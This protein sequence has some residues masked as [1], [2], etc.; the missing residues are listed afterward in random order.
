MTALSTLV[1]SLKREVAVP[2]TFDETFPS[3]MDSD[4]VATL[5]D[6]FGEAQLW[7]FF[8]TLSLDPVLTVDEQDWETS[9]PLSPGGATLVVL[10]AAARILRAQI[11][12]L[13]T[14]ERYKAGPVEVETQRAAGVLKDELDYVTTRISDLIKDAKTRGGVMV[15]VHDNYLNRGGGITNGRFHR[16][17]DHEYKG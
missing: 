12:S 16:F 11:R 5:A 15:T 17:Y 7:G 1:E 2:G 3:T 9:K 14:M 4:L 10:F 8:P 6:G 13:S